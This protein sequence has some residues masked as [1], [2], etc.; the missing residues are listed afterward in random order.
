MSYSENS[1]G[2]VS[3]KSFH[4][5]GGFSINNEFY[6]F[7]HGEL[8]KQ[9]SNAI[10]NNFYGVQ[11]DSSITTILNDQPESIKSF[12]VLN[13][14]GSQAKITQHNNVSTY[15]NPV[16]ETS[17][18]VTGNVTDAAGN[19]VPGGQLDGEY[20]NLNSK[21]G[22]YVDSFFT[23]EQEAS[24]P[25]FKEK[26]GKWFNYVKGLATVHIN[27]TTGSRGSMTVTSSNLD[28]Q[29]FSVQGIGIPSVVESESTGANEFKLTVEN[30]ATAAGGATW[31]ATPD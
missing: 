21:T 19:T 16:T 13:Y 26:E 14:E 25:E 8:W 30:A 28:Q 12:N 20:Y 24:I 6:T 3:F 18:V 9:H 15:I 2:W 27:D 17:S 23:N 29:E 4:P 11:Y 1:G 10:R 7:K 5:E 31:D 22:W